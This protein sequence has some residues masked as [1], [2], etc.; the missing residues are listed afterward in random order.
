[1]PTQLLNL[2]SQEILLVRNQPRDIQFE[3]QTQGGQAADFSDCVAARIRVTTL[4]GVDAASEIANY[5][6]LTPNGILMKKSFSAAE[7]AALPVG[8][9]L[10]EF[11]VSWVADVW[12]TSHQGS[13]QIAPSI[14]TLNET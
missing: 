7:I 6:D 14:F 13:V 3:G 8:T 9:F 12:I 2:V 10:Y 11:Q 1:M 4:F 5:T